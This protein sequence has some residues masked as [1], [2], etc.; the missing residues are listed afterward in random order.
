MRE[1]RLICPISI[2]WAQTPVMG[3]LLSYNVYSQGEG[4]GNTKT[5]LMCRI[6]QWLC[7]A[8]ILFFTSVSTS[9]Y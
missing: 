5:A 9:V 8:L 2:Q 6:N 4:G 3:F 7:L 1:E